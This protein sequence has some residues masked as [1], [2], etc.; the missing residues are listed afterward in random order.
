MKDKKLILYVIKKGKSY[1]TGN[2][3]NFSKSLQKA[4][5][6]SSYEN[7]LQDIKDY[8]KY[9]KADCYK[10]VKIQEVERE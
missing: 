1:L 8:I 10:K 6:Y 3:G 9:Y 4:Q 5:I 2:M 7:R